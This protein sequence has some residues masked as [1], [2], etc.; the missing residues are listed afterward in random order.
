M[1]GKTL[2]LRTFVFKFHLMHHNIKK[3]S[4]A[5]YLNF[6]LIITTFAPHLLIHNQFNE[7]L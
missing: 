2:C 1:K 6:Q 4:W 7:E 5:T 3:L